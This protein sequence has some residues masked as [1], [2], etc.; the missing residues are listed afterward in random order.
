M[1][2]VSELRNEE[3]P[4]LKS[5]NDLFATLPDLDRA[6]SRAFYK[7]ARVFFSLPLSGTVAHS[8]FPSCIQSAPPELWQLL[9]ALVETAQ[10]FQRVASMRASV[11]DDRS[12]LLDWCVMWMC[13]WRCVRCA[14]PKKVV[15]YS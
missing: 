15:L 12:E 1:A 7:K 8:L 3:L 5:I 9:R 14:A 6:L 11:H 4:Y 13:I 2:A 10:V